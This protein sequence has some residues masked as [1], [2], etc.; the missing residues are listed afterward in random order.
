MLIIFF[1]FSNN[2]KESKQSASI[3]IYN[4]VINQY[5]TYLSN[6]P[7]NSSKH[8]PGLRDYGIG[9]FKR[10]YYAYYDIN[11]D[12][13]PELIFSAF[14]GKNK[15]T[16]FRDSVN[17]SDLYAIWTVKNNKATNLADGNLSGP[18]WISNNNYLCQSKSQSKWVPYKIRNGRLQRVNTKYRTIF[19]SKVNWTD[20]RYAK[21]QVTWYK[22]N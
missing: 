12:G 8:F 16:K 18:W 1:L 2:K 3:T 5:K 17:A 11:L 15:P 4:S 20:K 13:T 21:S 22:L 10:G 19:G 6:P 9:S 7:S 14:L